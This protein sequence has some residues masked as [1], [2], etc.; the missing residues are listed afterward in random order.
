MTKLRPL[1]RL[2]QA[3]EEATGLDITHVHEDLVFIEYAAF[4]FRFDLEDPDKVYLHF[5]RDCEAGARQQFAKALLE[6]AKENQLVFL[7]SDDYELSQIEG[8]E[9]IEIKFFA[10]VE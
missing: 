8:K 7:S 6:R 2:R 1:G 4:M 3:V 10:K 5:N 9:E